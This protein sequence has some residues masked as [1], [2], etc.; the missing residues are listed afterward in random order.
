[1]FFPVVQQAGSNGGV[2]VQ[3]P[4]RDVEGLPETVGSHPPALVG[5]QGFHDL[6]AVQAVIRGEGEQLHQACGPLQ[7]PAAFLDRAGPTKTRKEPSKRRRTV[8]SS[9]RSR[10]AVG[11]GGCAIPFAL[12]RWWPGSISAEGGG[13][14]RDPPGILNGASPPRPVRRHL[15]DR[16]L[17]D[18][19]RTVVF[20]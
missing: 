7:S 13:R 5:P 3:R 19:G 20:E 16:I 4:A 18:D 2:R 17:V 8:R 11:S 9:P 12:L 10:R 6:V 14:R 15:E 1:M